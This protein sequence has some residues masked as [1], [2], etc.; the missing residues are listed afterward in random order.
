MANEE[1][2]NLLKCPACGG[3]IFNRVVTV[4]RLRGYAAFGFGSRF[5]DFNFLECN[6]C[7]EIPDV[8]AFRK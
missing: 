1:N 5:R 3:T 6:N 7:S 8:A 4:Q 2:L